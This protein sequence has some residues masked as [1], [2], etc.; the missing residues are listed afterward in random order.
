MREPWNALIKKANISLE[1]R[2]SNTPGAPVAAQRDS[3][4]MLLRD[5]PQAGTG[6]SLLTNYGLL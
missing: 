1:V 2:S 4:G 3:L 5:T 6:L